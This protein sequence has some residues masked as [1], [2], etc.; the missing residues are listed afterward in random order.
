MKNDNHCHH[1][2]G[3]LVS[4]RNAAEALAA[5]EGGADVIDVKEP[6]RGALGAADASTIASIVFAVNGRAPV[7]AAIGELTDLIGA[8]RD[9][10]PTGVSLFKIG[11]AGCRLLPNWRS[12]WR[13][14]I[15]AVVTDAPAGPPPVAVVY[16]DWRLASAPEPDDVLNAAIEARC[17][18]L[19]IDTWDKSAG[20]LF[21][22]WPPEQLAH[23]VDSIRSHGLIVVLAGSLTGETVVAASKLAPDLV[24]VRT[25]ACDG[26]RC[27]SVSVERVRAL[28]HT[29]R[30]VAVPIDAGIFPRPKNFLDNASKLEILETASARLDE[31]NFLR[32][33]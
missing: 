10:I 1:R 15:A 22:H 28:A 31:S 4:V 6:D 20:S 33:T 32:I 24:A 2:P 5:F 17:P 18:A 3:L 13:E 7:T 19:L 8:K 9:P 21:D 29:I 23:F 26:G 30:A 27:G 25:A 16:A 12:H 11:L 14:A